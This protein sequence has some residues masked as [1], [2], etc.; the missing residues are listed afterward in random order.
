[1]TTNFAQGNFIHAGAKGGSASYPGM[2][3]AALAIAGYA[4]MGTDVKISYAFLMNHLSLADFV[5]RREDLNNFVLALE[6]S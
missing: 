3:N 5:E 1:M 6:T 4:E 2:S